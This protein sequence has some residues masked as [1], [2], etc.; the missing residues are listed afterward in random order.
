MIDPMK[1]REDFPMFVNKV[2]MQ[3]QPIDW[4]DNASTTFKPYSVEKA[5]CS[6][7]ESHTSNSH[8]GDYD[9]CFQMDEK[10]LEVRG[11]VAAFLNAD[12]TEIVF[13]SGTTNSINLVAFGY[14]AKYLKPDDEILITQAEHASNVLPWF[15][16]AEMTGCKIGYIPLEKDGRL[17]AESLQKAINPHVKLVCI[18]HVTNVLGYIA[19][20]KEIA[21]ICHQ[22]GALLVAD[23]AQSVPHIKTDVKDLDVDFLSFSGHK[24]LGPTGIG[25]LYGKF[26]LLQKTDPFMTGGGMNAKF[27]M[28]GDVNYLQPPLRFEAGTQ[29]LEGIVGLGAAIDY[30]NKVGLD[31]IQAHEAMLKRYCVDELRKTGAVTIYNPLS[32]AGI[33]AF[34]V[35]GVFA[36]DAATYFNSKGIAVRSGQHCAKILIDFLQT[37]A[38]LRASFYLYTTKE[39]IDRLVDA[40]KTCKEGYL[41]AYFR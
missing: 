36:Q 15:K 28:C 14:G 17:T 41:N 16:V 35:D 10:I 7:Y 2:K 22:N 32:E 27:D 13:T 11:K 30:L 5:V 40:V 12:P 21:A 37:V 23:G 33:V 8:R 26:M 39:D 34:N 24:M 3:G 31:E 19:P 18:A 1:I 20:L 9:L 38:T 6:Y 4:L 25:V 29:N